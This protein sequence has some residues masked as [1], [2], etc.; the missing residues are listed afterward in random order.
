MPRPADAAAQIE[1]LLRQQDVTY[2]MR[3]SPDDWLLDAD[4]PA[5]RRQALIEPLR[6]FRLE[7]PADGKLRV[8]ITPAH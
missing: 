8:R 7:L 1:E 5:A 6:R 2:A 4:V 3:I